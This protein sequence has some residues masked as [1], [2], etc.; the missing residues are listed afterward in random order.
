[1]RWSPN[2]D[3]PSDRSPDPRA[4]RAAA[5]SGVVSR[6]P[7]LSRRAGPPRTPR[8]PPTTPPFPQP[9]IIRPDATG[10]THPDPRADPPTQVLDLVE[11]RTVQLPVT[12]ADTA[13]LPLVEP[14]VT[15]APVQPPAD[16]D[17]HR[18]DC[19]AGRALAASA[20]VASLT[21]LVSWL[22][23][24]RLLPAPAVGDAQ[25]V[26]SGLL[27]VGTAAQL[28]VGV[29]LRRWL[30]SAGRRAGRLVWTALAAVVL[31]SGG[32][33]LGYA[34][35]TPRLVDIA[36][37]PNGSLP[38]G[39]LVVAL[40]AAT[41]GVFAAHDAVLVALG[42]PWWAVW[43]NGLFALVQ[44]P[45]MV[46]L[47][48]VVGLGARGVL[49]S[50]GGTVLA[51]VVLGSVVIAVLAH[52]AAGRSS[53][54][55]LPD[56]AEVVSVLGPAAVAQLGAALLHHQVPVFVNLR[57]GPE[58][59]MA[60]FVAWQAVVV[61]DLAAAVVVSSLPAAG[62]RGALLAFLPGLLVGAVSAAPLLAVFGAVYAEA[63]D[64][65]RL[66]LLGSAARLIVV[67][68]QGVRPTTG[69]AWLQLVGAVLVL[70]VVVVTP[71]A[72]S[73][74]PALV[75]VAIAY[76]AAAVVG[77]VAVLLVPARRRAVLEVPTS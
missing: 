57:F 16:A 10:R 27:L 55:R 50:W 15:D 19:R 39:L 12:P 32:V 65:L 20:L 52:R 67:Y 34:W 38:V 66:L 24:A 45:A 44:I 13:Q 73:D 28:G 3:R 36:A 47:V 21:G 4:A 22:I 59:G 62:R 26:V 35:L 49:L 58:T 33:G 75:P 51:W 64:V 76:V 46:W 1:M 48:G 74:A 25:L 43:R 42:R 9:A 40:A 5:A 63:A 68:E 11:A 60:F 56:R 41:W 7:R 72:G 71:A 6:H 31:L 17:A 54:G 14:A 69:L 77:A 18:G 37:S 29:G 61:I 30:P 2:E 53:G 70:L 8:R 23:A